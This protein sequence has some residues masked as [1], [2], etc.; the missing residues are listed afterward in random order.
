MKSKFFIL[1]IFSLIFVNSFS[2]IFAQSTVPAQ[3]TAGQN[4]QFTQPASKQPTTN[5]EYKTG[6]TIQEQAQKQCNNIIAGKGVEASLGIDV[7]SLA[8]QYE[9]INLV[10]PPAASEVPTRDPDIISLLKGIFSADKRIDEN[11]LYALGELKRLNLGFF[12]VQALKLGEATEAV[13]KN[14]AK[15]LQADAIYN[16]KKP[17][18][19]LDQINKEV[20]KEFINNK[21]GATQDEIDALVQYCTK[22]TAS[23]KPAIQR[24]P[25]ITQRI[26]QSG[27]GGAWG[28]ILAHENSKEIIDQEVRDSIDSRISQK[29]SIITDDI[30]RTGVMGIYLCTKTYS[31]AAANTIPWYKADCKTWEQ[32]MS[33]ELVLDQNKKVAALPLEI[34][35]A[36]ILGED[37][38]ITNITNRLYSGVAGEAPWQQQGISSNFAQSAGGNPY[39]GESAGGSG[40]NTSGGGNNLGITNGVTA[41]GGSTINDIKGGSATKDQLLK[42]L[43]LAIAMYTL[44][45][46]YYASS[47]S[48][49][50]VLPLAKRIETIAKIDAAKAPIEQ[51]KT[52]IEKRWAEVLANP[53][54]D[55]SKFFLQMSADL[56]QTINQEFIKKIYDAVA[57]LLKVCVDAKAGITTATTT[58]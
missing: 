29:K 3:T 43:N 21:D 30:A 27:N 24:D 26:V 8:G 54:A 9:Q 4:F 33:A 58:N 35:A 19:V 11:T 39:F 16:L 13:K 51:K 56:G 20:C 31:G 41:G 6:G 47:T 53:T 49:C 52:D 46:T 2:L 12:C 25:S 57:K 40:V 15:V 23:P 17:Q 37:K 55:H 36:S 22:L 7:K 28:L 45:K 5:F 18:I 34:N 44:S 38:E 42:N 50:S 10:Q 48:A 32:E 14:V 1:A